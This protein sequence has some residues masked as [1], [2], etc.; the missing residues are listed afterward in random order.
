MCTTMKK[1]LALLLA[2]VTVLGCVACGAETPEPT[3][4]QVVTAP[5]QPPQEAAVL[6]VL[7]LGHSLAVDAGHM[8]AM[9]AAAEGY[10]GLKVATLYYS[11]CPLNKHVEFLSTNNRA[12]NLYVSS[13]DDPGN[14]PTIYEAVTMQ[15]AIRQ[16]YW[17]II[18]MQGGVF[19]IGSKETYQTGHIQTIQNYVNENK[20]YEGAIFAW[21]MAW[22][23]PVD[24][25]LRNSYSYTPNSYINNY[26][27]YDHNRT[28]LYNSISQC[29]N[30]YIM[31]DDSFTFMIPSGTVMENAL[32]SY[33]TE[34]DIH[35]DYVHASDLAR[36]M[37]SYTW[38]C[39]I[40][41]IEQLEE[42]KL[43]TV[44]KNFFKSRKDPVDWVLTDAEKA[45]ILESVNNALANPLQITPSQYT[46]APAAQ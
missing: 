15:E 8:L 3:E 23:P 37:V 17:D 7:T 32:S 31:T 6:K 21:N 13:T 20:L 26:E 28:A 38:F 14:V 5:T 27:K 25:D 29:V 39:R 40:T 18:I 36:V 44:P 45:I 42:I 10:Q 1:L 4:T 30:D 41:G 19:E 46:E 12:Y 43:D 24:D 22:A 16:D 34:K 9:I 35:R 2:L 33:L 11:G